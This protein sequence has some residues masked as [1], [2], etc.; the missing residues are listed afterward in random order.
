MYSFSVI[1]TVTN[2]LRSSVGFFDG[3]GAFKLSLFR[4]N[5]ET[6]ETDY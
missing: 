2:I 3:N 4:G 1:K 6:K 5:G